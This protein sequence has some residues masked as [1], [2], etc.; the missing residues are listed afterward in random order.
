MAKFIFE[1]GQHTTFF[2]ILGALI[3]NIALPAQAAR[4]VTLAWLPSEQTNVIG[5]TVHYGTSSRRYTRT[6]SVHEPMATIPDLTEGSSYYFAVTARN[7]LGFQSTP[8]AELAYTVPLV[9]AGEYSGLFFENEAVREYSAGSFA[10]SVTKRCAYTGHLRLGGR[11]YSFSGKLNQQYRGSNFIPRS[12]ATS[13]SVE[14]NIGRA[15][16]TDS[17]FGK[18]TDGTWVAALTGDRAIFNAKSRRTPFARNYTV[19]FPGNKRN[20]ASPGGDSFGRVLVNSRG[21][22]RFSGSLADGTKISQSATLSQYGQW[23]FYVPLY[24]GRGLVMS[25]MSFGE[26]TSSDV[27]GALRW[28]KSSDATSAIYPAGFI[29]D[30]EV[31]GSVYTTPAKSAGGVLAFA[32]GAIQ[33]SGGTSGN[34]SYDVVIG[35]KKII[36]TSG[37]L[38]TAKLSASDGLFKGKLVDPV[39]HISFPFQGA[40]LQKQNLGCG[41]FLGAGRSGRVL[42]VERP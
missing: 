42:L 39:T 7:S 35:S 8:S 19:I 32:D 28:I 15:S 1:P 3:L 21:M 37:S 13:L 29:H 10:L 27:N 20:P 4:S 30:C 22:V 18:V 14:L 17:L 40:I 2:W 9:P 23:P 33:C 11:R 25:W 34:F 36:D 5:Y 26:K 16:E 24:S 38:L 12:G 41:Y 6:V 31:L